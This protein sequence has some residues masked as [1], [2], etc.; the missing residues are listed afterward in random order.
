MT[1]VMQADRERLAAEYAKTI[2]VVP[3]LTVAPREDQTGRVV[4]LLDNQTA[5]I[6]EL[7]AKV[8]E[9]TL[10]LKGPGFVAIPLPFR[11]RGRGGSAYDTGYARAW[12]G[13]SFDQVYCNEPHRS[14]WVAGFLDGTR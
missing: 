13:E 6:V 5:R 10:R 8:R 3:E 2:P 1:D 4:E 11:G 9:L 7:E 12:R 14:A